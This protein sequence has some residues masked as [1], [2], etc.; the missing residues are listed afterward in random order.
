MTKEVLRDWTLHHMKGRD[1]IER[2]ILEIKEDHK[3]Y[4]L[5]IRKKDK[6]Q[7]ILVIPLLEN[8]AA[9]EKK[10]NDKNVIVIVSNSKPN[11]SFLLKN[12]LRLATHRKLCFYF[13]NPKSAADKRWIIYPYVHNSITE[14]S[15]LKKGLEA[16]FA[17]VEEA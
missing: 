8:L 6:D 7:F 17:S 16:L 9:L 11:L 2:S 15:A 5:V 4:D 14:K 12:W 10:L 3:G 1:A 13:V